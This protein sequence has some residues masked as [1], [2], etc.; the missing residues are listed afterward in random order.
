MLLCEALPHFPA[1][2]WLNDTTAAGNLKQLPLL[3]GA[4]AIY[5][6]ALPLTARTA[7]KR[8]EKVDL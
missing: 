4:L 8:Y 5:I 6:A 1:L 7:A 3:L 2:Q